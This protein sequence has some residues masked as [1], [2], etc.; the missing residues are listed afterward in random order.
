MKD[1]KS[2]VRFTLLITYFLMI[3][4]LTLCIALPFLVIW[5][6]EKMHRP[7]DLATVVMLTCY[8][9]APLAAIA[10]IS[11][12][13]F[14]KNILKDDIACENNPKNL[15]RL[16][17]CCFLAGIIMLVAGFFYMPFFISGASAMFCSI[18]V[19]AGCDALRY[20]IEK[21]KRD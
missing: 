16:S 19:K 18:V 17:L 5:Y 11:L 10:L 1:C 21:N 15:K 2:S 3:V 7:E 9:C 12:R 6:V 14:L 8:P 4:L 13:N 20:Y